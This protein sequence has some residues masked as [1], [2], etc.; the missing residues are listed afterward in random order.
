MM[1]GDI[2][3]GMGSEMG[4]GMGDMGGGMGSGMGDMGGGMGDM[5]DEMTGD[6]GMTEHGKSG[7]KDSDWSISSSSSLKASVEG[8]SEEVII[9]Q[10]GVA[11]A[12]SAV[13]LNG[14]TIC[15]MNKCYFV[16]H[17]GFVIKG[18]YSAVCDTGQM[19]LTEMP[20]C[21]SEFSWSERVEG[22]RY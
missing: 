2:G 7:M 11:Y 5:G 15:A 22:D 13:P 9:K 12:C 21:E 10:A 14:R 8:A 19:I 20:R 16:C 6:G 4:S 18:A 3:S 17:P 1:M